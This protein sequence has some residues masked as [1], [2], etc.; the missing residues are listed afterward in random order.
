MAVSIATETIVNGFL[1]KLR[2]GEVATT[3]LI[4][5]IRTVEAPMLLKTAGFDSILIDMEHSTLTLDATSQI[6][7]AALY[8]GITPIVRV[9]TKDPFFVSR[10]LDGGALG[11]IVP[12]IRSA[13]DARD[14]VNAA[15]FQPVGHRSATGG[16]PHLQF[17]PLPATIASP[18]VNAA[19]MVI[20][21]IETLEAVE[22][23]DAI[24]AVPGVDSLMVGTNDLTAEFGI[25]GQ[26]DDPKIHQAYLKIISA[27]KKHNIFLGIGGLQNRMDL[28]E[29]YCGLG[30]SWMIAGID[31]S[32]LLGAATKTASD[33]VSLGSRVVNSNYSGRTTFTNIVA[34]LKTNSDSKTLPEETM[35]EVNGVPA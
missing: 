23:V 15:K 28:L 22:D 14:V 13:Q 17:R 19:T 27:C 10:V 35:V 6:C 29:K 18:A 4:K 33:M 12:H 11:V 1:E 30:A 32:L 34:G 9:P 8:A 26:Y 2:R 3:C 7:L 5:L 25:P 21:M 24:A 20:P 31:A 16:L